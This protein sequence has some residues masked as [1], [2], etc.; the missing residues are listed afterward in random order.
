MKFG[1]IV[2]IVRNGTSAYAKAD[3]PPEWLFDAKGLIAERAYSHCREPLTLFKELLKAKAFPLDGGVFFKPLPE[4][5]GSY[6]FNMS[7]F[8]TLD[9]FNWDHLLC[10]D[11]VKAA[12][13]AD[14]K[15]AK[16]IKKAADWEAT[17][18]PWTYDTT[19][20]LEKMEM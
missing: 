17:S 4:H 19:A 3:I 13:D 16:R 11:K 10:M 8:D 12:I 7:M 2:E 15:E 14:K 1:M 18:K 6:A 5:E 20:K 9:D